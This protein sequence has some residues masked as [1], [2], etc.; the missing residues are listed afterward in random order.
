[1]YRIEDP[2][3]YSNLRE[4]PGGDIIREVYPYEQFIILIEYEG[5]Y[6]VEFQDGTR[7]FIESS[8]VVPAN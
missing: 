8:R 5:Y 1:M 3:G 7:G 6:G 2:D 4:I